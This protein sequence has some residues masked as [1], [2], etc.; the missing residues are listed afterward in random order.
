MVI[1]LDGLD[2]ALPGWQPGRSMFPPSL[3]KG[4]QIVFSARSIA[5]KDWLVDLGLELPDDHV[6]AL[7]QLS[8]DEVRDALAQSGVLPGDEKHVSRAAERLFAISEGDPFY[9]YDLLRDLKESHGDVD[10]LHDYPIGHNAY[11]GDWWKSGCR[12]CG[13]NAFSELLGYLALAQAPIS[14]DVVLRVGGGGAVRG[15]NYRLLM[16]TAARFLVGNES[17]GYQL[18]HPRIV[19]F[20]RQEMECELDEYRKRFADFSLRW[21]EHPS[22]SAR[23]YALQYGPTH[24]LDVGRWGALSDLLT[25]WP[26][27]ETKTQAGLV[28]ELADDFTDAVRVMP[29]A[30]RMRSTLAMLEEA[31]RSDT[32]F[33]DRHP[34]TLFQCLW[35]SCWW[36]DCPEAPHHY[37]IPEAGWPQDTTPW[38]H[39]GPKVHE[40]L[41]RWRRHIEST[42]HVWVRSL[43]PPHH[44]LGSD[45]V[46][47]RGH[48]QPVTGVDV[49]HDGRNVAAVASDGALIVWDA[50][51]G[52]ELARLQADV[53]MLAWAP[54]DDRLLLALRSGELAV[55]MP[56]SSKDP[57]SITTHDTR[58]VSIAW[59]PDGATVASG[60]ADG[61]ILLQNAV[62]GEPGVRMAYS[63][64]RIVALAFSDDAR[65][66]IFVSGNVIRICDVL[67]G[68]EVHVL[69]DAA[70][71][72]LRGLAVSSHDRRIAAIAGSSYFVRVWEWS[73]T[74]Q[75]HTILPI[76][77]FPRSVAF[78][79]DGADLAVG[80]SEGEICVYDVA[81]RK[82]RVCL[83]GH[84]SDVTCVTFAPSGNKVV[85]GS[86]DLS[87]R[88]RSCQLPTPASTVAPAPK[89]VG[90]QAEGSM[91]LS[92]GMNQS[93][94]SLRS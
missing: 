55:W 94:K 37:D 16:E 3:P 48:E 46:V 17:D 2:E 89:P 12:S 83:R 11:L 9:M 7:G 72:G 76:S 75:Q 39:E 34:T 54:S 30:H 84:E 52:K 53:R 29:H 65:H 74:P 66:L 51:R 24:L 86:N 8:P 78:S 62:T 25:Q 27:L 41:E 73:G 36:Y 23:Q 87:V 69:K 26:F 67:T 61:T 15:G 45:L 80:P 1:I 20:V 50:R 19:E 40:L 6:I 44:Q 22:G 43:R 38:L 93:T 18:S 57:A 21:A 91:T 82:E 47:L 32:H 33:I 79:P 77:G 63:N 14:R 28:F 10:R 4:M 92:S 70:K 81:T 49:S 60:M 58:V 71:D 90:S 5:N 56:H 85:S 68:Q 42:G 59:S 35:N 31:I 88:V 13:D 64:G